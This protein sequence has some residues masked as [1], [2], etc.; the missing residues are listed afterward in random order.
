LTSPWA[1]RAYGGRPVSLFVAGTDVRVVS[2]EV[3]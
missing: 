2:G 3:R 1:G